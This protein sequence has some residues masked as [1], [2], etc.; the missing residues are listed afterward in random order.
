MAVDMVRVEVG[1]A[2]PEWA[3]GWAALGHNCSRIRRA[4]TVKAASRAVEST[5]LRHK[6]VTRR[7]LLRVQV[8]AAPVG[9][10]VALRA[11]RAADEVKAA[12]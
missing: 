3:V 1:V 6:F 5:A 7:D 10:A 11:I 4:A 9:T 2:E 8:A 12:I